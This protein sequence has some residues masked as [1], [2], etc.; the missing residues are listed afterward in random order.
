MGTAK[1]QGTEGKN[2]QLR[3]KNDDVA[4]G[5]Y[6]NSFAITFNDNEFLMDFVMM[7]PQGKMG[8]VTNRVIVT[9]KKAAEIAKALSDAVK[10]Y[11]NMQK[12]RNLNVQ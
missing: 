2:V 6:A 8:L 11:E 12:T 4:A 5:S 10:A 9:P 7:Q 1:Q 3:I